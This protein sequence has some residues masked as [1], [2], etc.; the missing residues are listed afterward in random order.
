M[1]ELFRLCRAEG[2]KMRHTMLPWIHLGIP[3]L[4]STVFLS[5]YRISMWDAEMQI[6]GY[7]QVL[8]VLLPFLISIICARSIELEAENHFQTFLGI[9]PQKGKA[10]LAKAI[11]LFF[12]GLGAIA[13]AVGSFAA[14]YRI[15]PDREG[16]APAGYILMTGCLWLGSLPL[17][18]IHLFLNMRFSRAASLGTGAVEML[19]AALFLTGL[20]NG[21]WQMVPCSWSS[22]WSGSFFQL[23]ISGKT[24]KQQELFI[25]R[26]L[27]LCLL[28]TLI[29]CA[30]ILTGIHFYEG[31]QCDD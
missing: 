21:I 10:F 29:I 1:T 7:I 15:I 3:L 2:Y 4:G 13:L 17:Y 9:V 6:S 27:V 26:S 12:M 28:L 19:I 24:G 20:G 18:P 23:L 11:V 14:G 31:R 30:I 5:Y 16:L 8:G 22:R 25:I